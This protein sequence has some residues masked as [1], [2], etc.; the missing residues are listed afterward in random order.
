MALTSARVVGTT[1]TLK[2]PLSLSAAVFEQTTTVRPPI[3]VHGVEGR[4]AAA[5]YSSGFKQKSLETFDKELHAI[6]D[7]YD[8]NKDFKVFHYFWKAR[9]I[10]VRNK[11]KIE[12]LA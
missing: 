12:M 6:K 9:A 5:L 10:R 1:F 7:I 2:R 11:C 3:Q 4:Y 8:T